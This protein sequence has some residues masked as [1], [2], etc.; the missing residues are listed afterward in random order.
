MYNLISLF[1]KNWN[2]ELDLYGGTNSAIN[3]IATHA[4]A[5]AHRDSLWTLKFYASSGSAPF[6]TDGFTFVDS[7][8]CGL[9]SWNN[10]LIHL[11][12]SGSKVLQVTAHWIGMSGKPLQRRYLIDYQM[13][14]T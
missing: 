11:F 13:R 1:Q 4:T 14:S 10:T 2:V 6:P 8:K 7:K 12:Q 5:F 9:S 3:V